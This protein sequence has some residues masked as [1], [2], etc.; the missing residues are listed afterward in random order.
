MKK[1]RNN[2]HIDLIG[3]LLSEKLYE[4]RGISK[5]QY[6]RC[7]EKL[8]N[9][10][11]CKPGEAKNIVDCLM[12]N[13]KIKDKTLIDTTIDYT[14][15]VFKE[16]D[17]ITNSFFAGRKNIESEIIISNK[18]ERLLNNKNASEN[19]VK[20][21]I[22]DI[23]NYHANYGKGENGIECVTFSLTPFSE[24]NKTLKTK[25]DLNGPVFK[26]DGF[27]DSLEPNI[28][29]VGLFDVLGFSNLV[30]N[31]GSAGVIEK[32]QKLMQMVASK[33]GYKSRVKIK[34]TDSIFSPGYSYIPIKFAYF[35]DT[36]VIWTLAQPQSLSTFLARCADLICESLKI[37]LPLR[38][39]ITEG[40]AIMHKESGTYVGD[41]IVEIAKLESQ[42]TWVGA[43]LTTSIFEGDDLPQID[44]DLIVPL[45]FK[46]LKPILDE[47]ERPFIS[48]DWERQ[49]YTANKNSPISL[50]RTLQDS[51]PAK[52]KI[53][54]QNT[55]DYFEYSKQWSANKRGKFLRS[56]FSTFAGGDFRKLSL[57][58]DKELS[59][60]Y[61]FKLKSGEFKYG[62]II[63][64]SK[65]VK[66]KDVELK[67]EAE[68]SWFFLDN[69]HEAF[70]DKV[71]EE[72][73]TKK[74]ADFETRKYLE[75]ISA[76]SFQHFTAFCYDEEKF[77]LK[78]TPE[79][80]F[81]RL[82]KELK[83]NQ[84]ILFLTKPS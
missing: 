10:T 63:P 24:N 20:S 42:Q 16:M 56:M 39:A 36:I 64:F 33:N 4:K 14:P 52:N 32:Y 34:I 17:E 76:D 77:E 40:E 78:G 47:Y 45:Y 83:G 55:I 12:P 9:K 31:I 57:T 81:E 29:Y 41:A 25:I 66:V 50:L 18:L 35:S 37:G 48:L 49:W 53:Y 62:H 54:Y 23:E 1:D 82:K 27:K 84:K 46:H 38:G 61:I 60:P 70:L 75:K 26:E 68:R 51:A 71:F 69:K 19:D 80:E 72:L 28:Y 7:C 44:D 15:S 73:A 2:F 30:Q 59:G 8:W 58:I 65:K 79:E 6:I 21:I 43:T 11:K 13:V 5:K 74:F 22:N 67:K 3:D